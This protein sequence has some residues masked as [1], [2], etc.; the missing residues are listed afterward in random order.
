MPGD[1]K[2]KRKAK[3]GTEIFYMPETPPPHTHILGGNCWV[4][5]IAF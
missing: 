3:Q 1:K 2:K 5:R 4:Q